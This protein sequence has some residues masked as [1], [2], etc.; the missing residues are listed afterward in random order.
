MASTTFDRR[1]GNITKVF[2]PPRGL[3]ATMVFADMEENQAIFWPCLSSN[4]YHSG[5]AIKACSFP[6]YNNRHGWVLYVPL[7][8]GW[9]INPPCYL[10]YWSKLHVTFLTSEIHFWNSD[11][12]YNKCWPGAHLNRKYRDA[13]VAQR[14]SACLRPRAWSWSPRMEPASLSAYVSAFLSVSHE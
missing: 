9:S 7:K 5:E 6:E 4:R 1:F 12:L 8:T 11:I 14:L 3:L 13:W 2:L 10:S